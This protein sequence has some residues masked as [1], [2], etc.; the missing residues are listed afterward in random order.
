MDK[1]DKDALVVVAKALKKGL[2]FS[3]LDSY[4]GVNTVLFSQFS[5]QLT[6]ARDGND[7]DS[8]EPLALNNKDDPQG[9]YSQVERDAVVKIQHLWRSCSTKIKRRRLYTLLPEHRAITRFFNSSTHCPAATSLGDRKAIRKLL[10]LRGVPLSLRLLASQELL[11]HLQTDAIAFIENVE[12]SVGAFESIDTA[13]GRNKEAE[14]F[15]VQA[16]REMSDERLNELV[17][18]GLLHDL[19]DSMEKTE[20]V[21][22]KAEGCLKESREILDAMSKNCT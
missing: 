10:V 4:P 13:L 21:L 18:C 14:S 17:K 11:S 19:K 1:N 20:A 2:V 7:N 5:P 6:T 9:E 12:V 22:V 8:I 15:L 16:E 3:N